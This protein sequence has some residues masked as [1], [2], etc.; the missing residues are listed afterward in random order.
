M[1]IPKDWTDFSALDPNSGSI[2]ATYFEVAR[3]LDEETR[4]SRKKNGSPSLAYLVNNI[5]EDVEA[6]RI[7]WLSNTYVN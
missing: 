4:P 2:I 5:P 7:P 3:G 1:N 6:V